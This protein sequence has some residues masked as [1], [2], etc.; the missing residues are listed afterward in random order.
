M[1]LLTNLQTLFGKLPPTEQSDTLK[2]SGKEGP[3]VMS[4]E[5]RVL[6]AVSASRPSPSTLLKPTQ[7]LKVFVSPSGDSTVLQ[8]RDV[9]KAR[10]GDTTHKG[11]VLFIKQTELPHIHLEKV[12]QPGRSVI[13]EVN[14]L[15]WKMSME[16][17]KYYGTTKGGK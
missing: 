5:G 17:L 4:P 10:L 16:I 3:T 14:W 8:L 2:D 7:T 6:A 15:Q 9:R 12:D 11:L 1:G 13:R